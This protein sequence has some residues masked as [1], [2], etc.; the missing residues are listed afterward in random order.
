MRDVYI[1]TVFTVWFGVSKTI[2]FTQF[3]TQV[4]KEFIDRE[5][6][7]SYVNYNSN[8]YSCKTISVL[9]A[10]DIIWSQ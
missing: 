8:V 9:G 2:L 7:G 1:F 6:N 10:I 5:Y 4:P 3:W